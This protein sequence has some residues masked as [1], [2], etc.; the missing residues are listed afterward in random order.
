VEK[1]KLDQT[2]ILNNTLNKTMVKEDKKEK[3]F[4]L[5]EIDNTLMNLLGEISKPEVV[6]KDI[7]AVRHKK[8][9]KVL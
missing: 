8:K 6:G 9:R 5:G 1:I 2:M 7:N 4:N 3:N